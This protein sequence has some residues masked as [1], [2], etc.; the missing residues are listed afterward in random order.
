MVGQEETSPMIMEMGAPGAFITG[1]GGNGGLG[2]FSSTAR[3]GGG[4]GGGNYGGG[5]GGGASAYTSSVTAGE[6]V[7]SGGAGGQGIVII[8]NH[9]VKQATLSD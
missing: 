9:R 3:A 6:A 1:R 4:G 8:R 7:A 2:V 5:G